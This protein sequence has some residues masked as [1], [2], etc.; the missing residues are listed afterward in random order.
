ME[1]ERSLQTF[2]WQDM[3]IQDLLKL[4]VPTTPL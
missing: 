4:C 1:L 3:K 2:G